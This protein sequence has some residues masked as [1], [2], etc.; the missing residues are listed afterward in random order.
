MKIDEVKKLLKSPEKAD[1]EVDA[2]DFIESDE[3]Y[4]KGDNY[5]RSAIDRA[6]SLGIP[7]HSTHNNEHEITKL[8]FVVKCPYCGNEMEQRG[9][10]GNSD[11]YTI[12][13]ICKCAKVSITLPYNGIFVE[14]KNTKGK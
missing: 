4:Q 7:F 3:F 10:G 12:N 9:G 8:L 1:F 11:N 14:P 6:I 5:R 13:Y 2:F